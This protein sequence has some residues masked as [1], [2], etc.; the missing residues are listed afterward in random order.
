MEAQ[1]ILP[2]NIH[3]HDPASRLANNALRRDSVLVI[4]ANVSIFVTQ[5]RV[6]VV[7]RNR[8]N[9]R[10]IARA[11]IETI[12]VKA[13]FVVRII[14]QDSSRRAIPASVK[15]GTSSAMSAG[16]AQNGRGGPKSGKAG[17][18]ICW[19]TSTRAGWARRQDH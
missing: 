3:L 9:A 19:T 7:C 8:C 17:I 4:A 2:R 10:K 15:I 6:R 13:G 12:D 18:R 14:T 11:A 1:T 5:C 16:V